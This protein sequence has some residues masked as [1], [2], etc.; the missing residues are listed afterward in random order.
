MSADRPADIPTVAKSIEKFLALTSSVLTGR[1]YGTALGHFQ[2]YLRS[3]GLASTAPVD[4]VTPDLV[5]GFIAW[6]KDYLLR[7]TPAQAADQVSRSTLRTYLAAVSGWYGYCVIQGGWVP[8]TVMAYEHTRSTL[9]KAAKIEARV[10]AKRLPSDELIARILD[11]VRGEMPASRR[12]LSSEAAEKKRLNWLRNHA[13]VECLLTT[14]MRVSEA[15]A[16]R[17]SDLLAERRAAEI[18][19]KGHRH[20]VVF[21]SDCAWDALQ[22]YLHERDGDRRSPQAPLFAMHW[23]NK[24]AHTPMNPRGV[25][26]VFVRLAKRVGEPNFHLTPH[27]FRH[28]YATRLLHGT[29]N[30]ALVQRAL[31]HSSP[32]T[33]QIYASVLE[34]DL[35]RA[36]RE[37]FD[38]EP[39]D[40]EFSAGMARPEEPAEA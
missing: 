9:N 16:L 21:F 20:R 17:R 33:T 6:L 15:V 11:F 40:D 10:L 32:T 25:Q 38:E 22:R 2:D 39:E 3:R 18:L 35:R 19:G 8:I 14:G 37:V 28:W 34:E 24:E 7:N 30:I 13:L 23:I 31:G 26:R 29:H 27:T 1:T 4:R 36:H 12:E 5:L